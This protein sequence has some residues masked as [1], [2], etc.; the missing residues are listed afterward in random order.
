MCSGSAGSANTRS[1]SAPPGVLTA[2]VCA[3]RPLLGVTGSRRDLG[4]PLDGRDQARQ[5][6]RAVVILGQP[7]DEQNLSSDVELGVA[8]E[9]RRIGRGPTS[10]DLV[11]Y[12]SP[13]VLL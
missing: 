2:D 10:D 4:V 6:V 8:D 9:E 3:L 13:Q 5:S 7:T 1:H 11:A 12:L